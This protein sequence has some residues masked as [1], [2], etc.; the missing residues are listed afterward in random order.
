ME[1][2]QI[3]GKKTMAMK[4]STWR[5]AFVEITQIDALKGEQKVM[6]DAELILKLAEWIKGNEK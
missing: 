6:L 3:M 4:L 1:T 2:K 5:G